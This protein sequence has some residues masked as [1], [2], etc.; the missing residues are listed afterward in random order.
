MPEY[1]VEKVSRSCGLF[2]G[3]I[4][5]VFPQNFILV[6]LSLSRSWKSLSYSRLLQIIPQ[7]RS[8]RKIGDFSSV[9]Q[10]LF[11]NFHSTYYYDDYIF[12]KKGTT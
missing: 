1:F 11:H 3:K 7:P 8:T 2:V 6:L 9:N 4:V 12:N 10:N 5:R